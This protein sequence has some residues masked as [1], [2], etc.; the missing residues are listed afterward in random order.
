MI[1]LGF[2][3]EDTEET[4]RML[5]DDVIHSVADGRRLIVVNPQGVYRLRQGDAL[6]V[7]AKS[8]PTKL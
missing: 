4:R 7:I 3:T 8:E 2:E 6:F 5:S 1:L